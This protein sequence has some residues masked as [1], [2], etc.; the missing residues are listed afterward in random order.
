M[1]LGAFG[2]LAIAADTP[3]PNG[4][5]AVYQ[6]GGGVTC[7]AVPGS[8]TGG[9]LTIPNCSSGQYRCPQG[10]SSAECL[11]NNPITLWLTFF[12]NLTAAIIGV[13]A[14]MMVIIAGLQYTAA[15]DNPQAIQSAKQKITNVLIGLAAFIF[16]WAFL[17][18]LI[19]GG[20]F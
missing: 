1:F 19:P 5:Q 4:Q 2:G 8:C 10:A 20:V 13:G 16:L 6:T 17:Q 15:R 18:W 3:C 9:G 14:V 12:I 11:K 7:V